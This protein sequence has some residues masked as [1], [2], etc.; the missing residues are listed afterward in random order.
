MSDPVKLKLTK[1]GLDAALNAEINGIF[2]KLDK[3]KFSTDRFV[4]VP[5]DLRTT[6]DNVVHESTIAAGGTSILQNTLRLFSVIDSP[7]AHSIGSI[8]LYTEDGVL[9]AIASV[10][11][12]ELMK[13]M[14]R[15][16]FTMSFGMTLSALL[17]DNID[18]IIDE[19]SALAAALMFQHENHND[20]HPQYSAMINNL[21]KNVAD[22]DQVLGN[23]VYSLDSQYPK[24]ILAGVTNGASGTIDVSSKI[25]DM[26][27]NRFSILLTPEGAHEAWEINRSKTSFSYNIWNRSGMS[28]VGYNGQVNWAIVQNSANYQIGGNGDYTLAGTYHIPVLAGETKSITLIG[29]GGGGGGSRY[30]GGSGY[31]SNNGKNG[32]DTIISKSGTALGAGLG[33][34]GGTVGIWGNGSSYT[35]GAAGAGGN[36]THNPSDDNIF[37]RSAVNGNG[38]GERYD[39][40]G[41]LVSE[42]GGA[43]GAGQNGVGDVGWSFGGGGGAGGLLEFTYKNNTANMITLVLVV[44][45]GGLQPTGATAVGVNGK[46][47]FAR[48]KTVVDEVNDAEFTEPGSF[49]VRVG[50]G[51]TMRFDLVAAGAGGGCAIGVPSSSVG[52]N[53]NGQKGGA[54]SITV[55]G[56]VV[57]AADS[58]TGGELGCWYRPPAIIIPGGGSPQT[59]PIVKITGKAGLGGTVSSNGSVT[60][61]ESKN[62]IQGSSDRYNYIGGAS[63]SPVL[64]YGKGG[65][66][67][68]GVGP[69]ADG[70]AGGAGSGAYLSCTYH[71]ATDE[72]VMVTLKVG[73][74]G[75][76]G[77]AS[78]Y[79]SGKAGSD[80]YARVTKL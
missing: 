43:G 50:A 62:G 58:G 76:G 51:S 75:A 17:L 5:N 54:T 66:G 19:Q 79:T 12:G 11:T 46:A 33:G 35:N 21:S 45:E 1:V 30:S 4:S 69:N 23:L 37:I 36:I 9:F 3:I 49:Q 52:A 60:V 28:R 31:E 55:A 47:G 34:K 13:M 71:N 29:G 57:A 77:S 44:G 63:V 6:L 41:G 78:G 18:V 7:Q 59:P 32:Q 67:I 70:W 27:D 22:M 72:V 40:T 24:N 26:R 39:H 42:L 64:T 2:I 65:A 48:I 8:G 80:G 15:I 56:I 16:S 61:L 38:K 73:A 68:G 20:P 14:P 10:E 53:A 25:A 74:G